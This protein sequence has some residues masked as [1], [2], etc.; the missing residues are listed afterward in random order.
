MS[1]EEKL[2]G[3]TGPSSSTEQE[4]QDRTERM[5]RQAI[6]SHT[7]FNN[8]SLKIYAKGLTPITLMFDRI[9]TSTLPWSVQTFSIGRS[10]KKAFIRQDLPIKAF[11]PRSWGRTHF[12]HESHISRSNR[13]VGVYSYTNKLRLGSCR[14]WCRPMLQ[15]PIPYDKWN[16]R[17]D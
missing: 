16:K 3:W 17:W 1:L 5:I 8:C 14:C 9:V 4:K 15:F 11:G 6:N 12:R 7:P 13:Y 10:L 2:T